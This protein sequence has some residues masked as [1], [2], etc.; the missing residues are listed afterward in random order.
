MP[1][2]PRPAGQTE[3]R[4]LRLQLQL[5]QPQLAQALGVSA[6]TLRTWDS[7]RRA[8]PEVWLDKARGLAAVEDPRRLWSLQELATELGVHVRTLRDAARSGRL[9]VSYE[10]R[11]VFRNL[12]PRATMAAGRAFMERYYR[13]SYSRFAQKPSRPELA[14]VP[15]DWARCLRRV[16]RDLQLTQTQLAERIGAA[17][18]AVVYQWES[19]KRK[20]SP[21][22]WGRVEELTD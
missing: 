15:P 8:V 4:R 1:R 13:Q 17:G 9:E 7:G 11:V 3:I 20:P 22:F 6:E 19:G 2:K 10:N 14:P 12:I 18:K 5:S 21:V 16:R